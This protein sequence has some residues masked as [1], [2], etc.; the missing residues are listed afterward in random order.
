MLLRAQVGRKATREEEVLVKWRESGGCFTVR[1]Y[2]RI[3]FFYP[4]RKQINL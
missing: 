2:N 1:V 3:F 4:D